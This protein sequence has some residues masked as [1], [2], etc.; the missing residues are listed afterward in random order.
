[1]SEIRFEVTSW[2]VLTPAAGDPLFGAHAGDGPA[3]TRTRLTK[4]YSGELEGES[5]VEMQACGE[6]GY[7][8]TERVCGMLG[9]RRGTFVLQHGATFDPDGA[10]RQFGWVAK[11]SG[12]GELTGL[13]GTARV[14]HGLLSL[15]WRLPA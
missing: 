9:G 1:M 8:A 5:V 3:L 15:D 10:P 11:G 7:V 6:E 4:R 13:S 14:E 12:S 2:D